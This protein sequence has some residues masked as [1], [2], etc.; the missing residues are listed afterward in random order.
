MIGHVCAGRNHHT[1][2]LFG[3]RDHRKRRP[4]HTQQR[5]LTQVVE[6]ILVQH[7]DS[8]LIAVERVDPLGRAAGEHG[9]EQRDVVPCTADDSR[10]V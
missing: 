5:H 10:S 6:I 3:R 2:A 4:A 7:R 8:R 1:A 9:V